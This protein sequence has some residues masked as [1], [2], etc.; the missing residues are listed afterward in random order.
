MDKK[1]LKKVNLEELITYSKQK[2]T[3]SITIIERISDEELEYVDL[4]SER[5]FIEPIIVKN[6]DMIAFISNS[7]VARK[8]AKKLKKKSQTM[9]Y[10]FFKRPSSSITI[11]A[12]TG[13]TK[14]WNI[15]RDNGYKIQAFDEK[16]KECETWLN[17][18]IK[19]VEPTYLN[20]LGLSKF[21]CS[22][23]IRNKGRKKNIEI[24]R[25]S[26]L[27]YINDGI[28]NEKRNCY[29]PSGNSNK[30]IAEYNKLEKLFKRWGF[31]KIQ[32]K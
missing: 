18:N 5:L 22:L 1:D 16:G 29:Y 31:T 8:I 19:E 21:N 2:E 7:E 28:Y 27:N 6:T 13:Y 14:S 9:Y 24:L 26:R 3:P 17:T 20:S 30:E 15:I 23:Q 12:L 4:I 25:H 10:D 32:N 11:F